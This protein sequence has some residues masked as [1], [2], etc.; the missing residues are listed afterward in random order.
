MWMQKG[1]LAVIFVRAPSE[2]ESVP[3]IKKC[4][5]FATQ[6]GFLVK[7][8]F[9]EEATS[10]DTPIDERQI[11]CDML[12]YV[13]EESMAAIITL[14]CVH[15]ARDLAQRIVVLD[16]LRMVNCKFFTV[17]ECSD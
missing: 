5:S 15:L 8:V 13:F 10:Y 2:M 9:V 14:S 12:I 3:A 4:K 1:K 6:Q 16:L 17:I 11:L 7:Q